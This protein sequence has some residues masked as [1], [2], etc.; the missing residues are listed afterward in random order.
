MRRYLIA[1]RVQGVGFRFWTVGRARLLGL[2]GWVRNRPDG[3]VEV[4]ARGQHYNL[5]QLAGQLWDGPASAKVERVEQT[6]LAEDSQAS[7]R[8]IHSFEQIS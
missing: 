7:L 2:V 1:G 4:V 8:R 6:P 3:S 5:D